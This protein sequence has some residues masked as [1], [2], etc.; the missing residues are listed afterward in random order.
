MALHLDTWRTSRW[1]H[2]TLQFVRFGM[3]GASGFLVNEGLLFLAHGRAHLPLLVASVLAIECAIIW[4]YLLND[5]WTFHHP[6]PSFQRFWPFEA[7][8][9]VGLVVNA[10]ILAG[11]DHYAHLYYLVANALAIIAA[12][13]VNYL[14]NAYWTYGK[15]L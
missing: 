5:R 14:L 13:G 3:V 8:S 15:A 6:R 9:L 7:V 10:G 2:S 11:L 12:M 1:G 4:N